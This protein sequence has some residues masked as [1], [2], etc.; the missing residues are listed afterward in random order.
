MDEIEILITKRFDS[1]NQF[2]E[3]EK[4]LDDLIYSK[5]LIYLDKETL[6]DI[7]FIKY[8]DSKNSIYCLSQ[9]DLYWRG[10]FLDYETSI[11][12]IK[13]FKKIEKSNSFGCMV[14]IL[15]IFLI[16]VI[17]IIFQ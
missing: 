2:R 14:F 3:F 15:L 10:F 11:R 17:S 12:F 8:K 13:N 4:K 1:E 7:S 16:G 6:R 5:K 9:P